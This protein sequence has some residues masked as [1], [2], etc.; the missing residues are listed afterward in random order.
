[1]VVTVLIH[2]ILR[3]A[4]TME[5]PTVRFDVTINALHIVTGLF[6]FPE[7]ALLLIRDLFDVVQR[8]KKTVPL[9]H[10]IVFVLFRAV[11]PSS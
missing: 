10:D 11:P 5:E 8:R 4:V 6:S 2:A 9:V 3:K 7:V 1:M